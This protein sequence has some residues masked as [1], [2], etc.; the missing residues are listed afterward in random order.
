[1]E[2]ALSCIVLLIRFHGDR[3]LLVRHLRLMLHGSDE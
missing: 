3:L 2:N 1:M